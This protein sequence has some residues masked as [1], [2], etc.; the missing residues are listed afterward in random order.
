ML[1]P[2]RVSVSFTFTWETTMMNTLRDGIA[3]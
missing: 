2:F 1:G 3:A